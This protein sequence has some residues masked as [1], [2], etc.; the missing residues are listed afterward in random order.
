MAPS[1][2][3]GASRAA[4]AARR[5]WKVGD[6]VLAKLKGFPAWPATVTEPQKWDLKSDWKKVLVYFF[7][8]QQIAFCNPGDIE[9]FTEEKKQSLSTKRQGKSAD[10]IRALNEI[11][12]S[13]EKAKKQDSVNDFS[14]SEPFANGENSVESSQ[15]DIESRTATSETAV[16]CRDD[17]THPD[18]DAAD[19][20]PLGSF[21]DKEVLLKQSVSK[22]EK[23]II[24]TY[25]SRKRSGGSRSRKCVSQKKVV[26][27]E[28]PNI[29]PQLA[30]GRLQNSVLLSQSSRENVGGLLVDSVKEGSVRRTKRS[31]KSP[32]VVEDEIKDFPAFVSNGSVEDDV[33]EIVT[34]D[35]GSVSLNDVSTVDSCYKVEHCEAAVERSGEGAQLAKGL[36]F[37]IKDVVI[38]KKR[39]PN[40]KRATNE[41]TEPTTQPDTGVNLDVGANNTGP[42][43]QLNSRNQK[44]TGGKED[45]DE[46]LPL[47][48]RAR[49][50]MGELPTS[51]EEHGT[52]Q[53]EGKTLSD[54]GL[55]QGAQNSVPHAEERSSFEI[56]VNMGNQV[57]SSVN[58][59]VDFLATKAVNET[60]NNSSPSENSQILEG[61][62]LLSRVKDSQPFGNLA[63]GESAL[64]PS[65]RLH[66][67]LE[68]MSANAAEETSTPKTC[69]TDSAPKDLENTEIGH[70]EDS[71]GTKVPGLCLSSN[72]ALEEGTRPSMKADSPN[73][74]MEVSSSNEASM[75][76]VA[77]NINHGNETYHDRP[78]LRPSASDTASVQGQT[79]V[80]LMLDADSQLAVIESDHV[81][82]DQQLLPLEQG[83]PE[84]LEANDMK[85]ETPG[86]DLGA[87]E[88]DSESTILHAVEI[89]GGNNPK[90]LQVN[91]DASICDDFESHKSRTDDDLLPFGGYKLEKED[92]ILME[93]SGIT[94]SDDPCSDKDALGS[95]LATLPA[96]EESPAGMS[97]I[98][99]SMCHVSTS[100]SANFNQNSGG[101]SPNTN[102]NQR[103]ASGTTLTD[104][105]KI[106]SGALQRPKSVGR[107]SNYTE[108]QSALSSFEGMLGLLTRTKESI[109]RATR[110]AMDC[111]KFGASEKAMEILARTLECESSLHRRVDL[112]F[113]V[114]SV[115]QCSRG[116][117]GDVDGAYTSAIKA[118][119]PRLLSSA[120]PP[121]N[122]AL[123]N[124]RQCLK[125]LRLWLQRRILPE[126]F[127]RHHIR[128]LDSLGAS[129]SAAPYCRRSAR[130]ERALDDPI[131]DMEGMLVDEYGSNSSF[132]LPGFCMPRML[133]DEDE[134]S[135]S[136]GGS[137]EAV[138]PEHNF[139]TTLEER[140]FSGPIAPEKHTHILEDVDGELEMEDVA[141]ICEVEMS[142]STNNASHGQFEQHFPS[143][144]APPP[145]PQEM[146]PSCPPL[147]SS[148]PPPP[149][150]PPAVGHQ[151]CGTRD[152]HVSNSLDARPYRNSHCHPSECSRDQ[153]D[154][155]FYDNCNTSGRGMSNG[156]YIDGPS[157]RHKSHPPRPSHLPPANHYS[158]VHGGGQHIKSRRETP[159][160]PPPPSYS[161][162]RY[163]SSHDS[164]S[165]NFYNNHDRMRPG[166]YE[167]GENWRYGAPPY[168]GHRYPEKS[169]SSYEPA[170][171]ARPSREPR[172]PHHQ[173]WQYP[174][175][176]HHR[177]FMHSDGPVSVTN[178]GPNMWRHR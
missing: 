130:T 124:R 43:L 152:A 49:V 18:N 76:E 170:P 161:S 97:P 72:E 90:V 85:V 112:F 140:E 16:T 81:P 103:R 25:T 51:R 88:K 1:R 148:P 32:E 10:F 13:F 132:Q 115:A 37:Q 93:A 145:L 41:A 66:R 147:P 64:P 53:S 173:G 111:A 68:A 19:V 57:S 54:G 12:D 167:F 141:P 11:I 59:D 71:L 100:E 99:T 174:P 126:S 119:L 107:C 52:Y 78:G 133:K 83:E 89:A 36:D 96:D 69:L 60:L 146:P 48:K 175:R 138:T 157:Y 128:E 9:P 178:R 136:D 117:K 21:D 164:E 151:S 8:T 14:S 23:P 27:P 58:S 2:R 62:V 104:D 74:K 4:A 91:V 135:D 113:L 122:L 26:S 63:V 77:E 156:H 84:S 39:K 134:G 50:R 95:Q 110:I 86:K 70:S 163:H 127:I 6:L 137:F 75:N 114:D 106:D 44:E 172:L 80:N 46:H 155:Q 73:D 125:V 15:N 94:S 158:Y 30:S 177:E 98:T 42:N 87:L 108:A 61:K 102:S 116:L 109:G 176:G 38:R 34:V 118:V 160:P 150:L 79:S 20:P 144:Y 165:G 131:R 55:I 7:G 139:E 35:S 101:S 154:L 169:R 67:A 143:Q 28:M 162:H 65:K 129:T 5:Q 166:P 168:P 120:A 159:P 40:R 29:L 31:R 92:Q 17:P 22:V 105:E 123:E 24:A 82:L 56:A 45:G 149:P 142:S 153:A 3:R 121:G 47:V 171:Y 33:S